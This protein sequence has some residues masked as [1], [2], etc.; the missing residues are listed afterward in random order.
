MSGLAINHK[1]AS[2]SE[3]FST[4]FIRKNYSSADSYMLQK[5]KKTQK[6]QTGTL[7]CF[8]L[9]SGLKVLND[10]SM[11]SYQ[12]LRFS[13]PL[14]EPYFGLS[15]DI[16]EAVTS[17]INLRYHVTL[18]RHCGLWATDATRWHLGRRGTAAS[19]GIVYV[20]VS[21]IRRATK[22]SNLA[23]VFVRLLN[24]QESVVS[25]L[26]LRAKTQEFHSEELIPT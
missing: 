2:M 12:R 10:S 11:Y 25:I 9:M 17:P 7:I 24:F 6:Q 4:D 15:S 18:L 5:T 3:F 13:Q 23:L 20:A 8:W 26:W 21:S 22:T 1:W 16:Q 14:W 19:N